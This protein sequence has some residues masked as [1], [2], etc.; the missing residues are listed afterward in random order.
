MLCG[1]WVWLC[2]VGR[3]DLV[4]LSASLRGFFLLV[5]RLR[6]GCFVVFLLFLF[7]DLGFKI[8]GSGNMAGIRKTKDN[9]GVDF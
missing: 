1:V 7:L 8:S 3:A 5:A 4:F 6:L 2:L 9:L